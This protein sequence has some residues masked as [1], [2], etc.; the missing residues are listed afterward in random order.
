METE[1]ESSSP[2]LI[3]LSDYTGRVVET[4]DLE[5]LTPM[6]DAACTHPN[7]VEDED[8]LGKAYKCHRCQRG[9]IV[10]T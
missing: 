1:P 10:Q 7:I 3:T 5:K 8:P 9:W 4:I 2:N 6:H